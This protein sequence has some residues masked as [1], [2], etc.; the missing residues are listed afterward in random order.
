MVDR[1]ERLTNLIALLL[2]AARP[3]TL[4]EIVM[5][6]E[7]YPKEPETRRQAFERDKRLLRD[8]GVP[9]ETVH[10]DDGKAAYRISSDEYYLPP[11][12]L[13]EDELVALNLAVAA[14]HLEGGRG[15]EALWSLG[16]AP[17]EA[18]PPLAALPVIDAL[19]ALFDGCRRRAA[20][21]FSY[22]GQTR[23]LEPWGM[24][25]REGFWYVAGRDVDRSEERVFRADRIQGD[26]TVGPPAAFD[27]P[28]TFDPQQVMPEQAFRMAMVEPTLVDVEVDAPHAAAA[29]AD[30]GGEEAVIDRR[31]DGGVTLRIAVAN[32]DAFRSWIFGFLDHAHVVA[33]PAVRTRFVKWLET[34]AQ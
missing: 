12:D 34:M 4:D 17:A 20:V 8:E 28:E 31:P 9:V 19:P 15:S 14:V 21:S 5:S 24:F 29:T 11:L 7:G 25:F 26:V 32:P 27:R 23:T 3:I 10:V 2:N 16:D 6:I 22:R 13:S 1:L 18:L 30:A 33:P